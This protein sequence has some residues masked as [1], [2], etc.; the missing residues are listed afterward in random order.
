MHSKRK[1]Q[2]YRTDGSSVIMW[3]AKTIA[4]RVCIIYT[5]FT[6]R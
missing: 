2:K 4:K 6:I 5:F 1:K 3:K